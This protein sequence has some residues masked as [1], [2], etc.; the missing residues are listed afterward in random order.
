MA[1]VDLWHPGSFGFV[2]YSFLCLAPLSV[3]G[4]KKMGFLLLVLF[5]YGSSF[6]Y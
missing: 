4:W 5:Y 3:L 1:A 6:F 2:I